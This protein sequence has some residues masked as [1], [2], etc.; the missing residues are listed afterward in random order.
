MGV[1]VL[2]VPRRRVGACHLVRSE[3]KKTATNV[4]FENS[5][6]ESEAEKKGGGGEKAAKGQGQGCQ[7]PRSTPCSKASHTAEE[8]GVR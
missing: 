4:R 6:G 5:F 8:G 3:K 7:S 2:H 1:E